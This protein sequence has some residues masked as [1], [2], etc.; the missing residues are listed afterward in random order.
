MSAQRPARRAR[1]P[2]IETVDGVLIV[3]GGYAGVHASRVVRERGVRATIVD[4]S[5]RH[6]FVTRLAAVA[7]GTAPRRDASAPLEEFCD[8][9]IVA[10]VSDV[11]VESGVVKL[12]DGR[13]LGA[14]AVVITAGAVPSQPPIDG[15][16][17]AA[18]L[19][20]ADDALALRETIRDA[21][22]VVIVGGGATG[23]QLAGS[24]RAR[25]RAT[26]VTLIDAADRLLAGM[27]SQ[28]SADALRILSGRR[29]DVRLGAGV[30]SITPEGVMVDGELIAGVPVWAGGYD[31]RAE[32][33]GVAAD[34]SD[35]MVV[36]EMLLVDG[37]STVFAAGDVAAHRDDD[38][39]ELAMS[40]QIAVQAGTGAGENAVRLIAGEELRAVELSHLGWVLDLGGN[41]GLAE[42]AGR[43]LSAPFL[44]L[45]P[46]LL[47]WGIDVRH[48]IET[49]G[50]AGVT[51][52]PGC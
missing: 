45:L 11:D 30:D 33:L 44:D 2:R 3:G 18:V 6:D 17:H 14:D 31:A 47:H 40:A 32:S 8:E 35:R 48:L 49:R 38:G 16:E 39:N 20:T 19:R 37:S 4:A 29:V 24:I 27:S 42:V 10:T 25:R 7:G 52:R 51:H 21:S 28:L 36:D 46:P 1:R 22:S 12:D 50:L 34:E 23:V 41:R 43:P 9:V 15:L 13:R 26:A 5:G